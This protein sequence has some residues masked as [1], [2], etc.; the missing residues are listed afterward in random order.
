LLKRSQKFW[1]NE[2]YDLNGGADKSKDSIPRVPRK[3]VFSNGRSYVLLRLVS[4]I[5]RAMKGL[6]IA[7]RYECVG[8]RVRGK[9]EEGGKA[10]K[11]GR[12][13]IKRKSVRERDQLAKTGGNKKTGPFSGLERSLGELKSPRKKT[14]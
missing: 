3:L 11:K 12:E 6:R 4:A 10:K 13:S 2:S 5:A 14:G 8:G 9:K 7:L 1:R